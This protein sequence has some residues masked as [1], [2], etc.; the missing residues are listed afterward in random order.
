MTLPTTIFCATF[1]EE[2]VSVVLGQRW[3]DTV[4]LF[5]LLTP[6]ILVFGI[7]NPTG[8]LLQSVGLHRRSLHIALVIAPLVVAA[9]VAGL[10]YGAAG[11]AFAFSA[12]MTL[13]LVP[14]VIWCTRGTMISVSDLLLAIWR[15]LVASLL[16]AAVALG[17]VLFCGAGST[18]FLRFLVGAGVMAGSYACTLLFIM[19]QL[20]LY[21]DLLKS[22]R[23]SSPQPAAPSVSDLGEAT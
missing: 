2:I 12:A 18:P 7:I 8:W 20:P 14:H 10:P 17:A 1:A 6:T 23:R 5:R 3:L 4:P 13:W 22:I 16:S 11:V 21:L 19:R 9:C 15:P